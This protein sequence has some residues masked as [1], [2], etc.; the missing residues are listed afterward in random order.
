MSNLRTIIA[1]IAWILPA[2]FFACSGDDTGPAGP[3]GETDRSP[4]A[5]I[6]DARLVWPSSGG[7]ATLTWTAPS[8]NGGET[9]VRYEIRY[10]HSEPLDWELSRTVADPPDPAPAGESQQ[11]EFASPAAGKD[12][13][14]AI[15]SFDAAGNASPVSPVAGVHITGYT[16]TGAC[17]EPVSGAPVAGVAVSVTANRVVTVHTGAD[18]GYE[19]EDLAGGAAHVSVRSGGSGMMFHDYDLSVDLAGETHFEHPVVLYEAADNPLGQNILRLCVHAALGTSLD[20]RLKKWAT[21]PIDV[22]VPA[23]VNGLGVDYGDYGKRAVLQWNNRTGL[24]IFNIVDSPPTNGIEL[25]FLPRE[26]IA[27]HNG[28]AEIEPDDNGFPVSATIRIIDDLGAAE[29]WSIVLHEL[30]HTIH[31]GHLPRGYLMYAGQ[32]LPDDITEDEVRMIQLFL[33]LPNNLDLGV[34]DLAPPGL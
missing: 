17:Y 25:V 9:V 23:F 11:Y 3:A 32:P 30:G 6:Q 15:R 22:Y 7:G 33:A 29:M 5:R 13:Y 20:G 4:P 8:D 2:A 10:S 27:P 18:G 24:N 1:R 19:L 31:I 12:L 14:A 21:Y 16:V 26:Q 34:Y 28:L